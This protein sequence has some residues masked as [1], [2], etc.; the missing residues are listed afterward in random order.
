MVSLAGP[1]MIKTTSWK[2]VSKTQHVTDDFDHF[3]IYCQLNPNLIQQ[4]FKEV[5]IHLMRM[6]V[7]GWTLQF[8]I[9]MLILNPAPSAV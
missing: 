3:K 8:L 6:E 2:Q 9:G 1:K 5:Q 4:L 7:L